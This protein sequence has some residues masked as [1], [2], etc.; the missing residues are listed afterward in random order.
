MASREVPSSAAPGCCLGRPTHVGNP[1]GLEAG[2]D[3]ALWEST[4][5]DLPSNGLLQAC[6][7]ALECTFTKVLPG[8]ARH[9]T[10]LL[11]GEQ[12]G[13]STKVLPDTLLTV[14]GDSVGAASSKGAKWPES[15]AVGRWSRGSKA[16]VRWEGPNSLR[17][18]RVW[19]AGKGGRG[20]PICTFQP[21]RLF[22]GLTR[23][24]FNGVTRSIT[25]PYP[26]Y[27]M[28]LPGTGFCHR[29]RVVSPGK[30]GYPARDFVTG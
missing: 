17:R 18:V 24:K 8:A 5:L 9:L 2:Y 1:G 25:T 20:A 4:A 14:C 28:G 27:E 15:G 7:G 26:V 10:R 6:T 11:P 19:G 16:P 22:K 12:S 29:V 21:C 30:G 13:T 23:C 3:P